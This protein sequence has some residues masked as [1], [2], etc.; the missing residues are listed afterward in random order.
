M[1]ISQRRSQKAQTEQSASK[2]K[3]D[4]AYAAM[5]AVSQAR[6]WQDEAKRLYE[7]TCQEVVKAEADEER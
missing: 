2:A 1:V 6:A 4:A 3:G 5:E 7:Q